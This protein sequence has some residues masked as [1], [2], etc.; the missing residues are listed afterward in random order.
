MKREKLL[1]RLFLSAILMPSNL[2]FKK[3]QAIIP[4]VAV[5]ERVGASRNIVSATKTESLAQISV[6][7]KGAKTVMAFIKSQ[8]MNPNRIISTYQIKTLTMRPYPL[9]NL[10]TTTPTPTPTIRH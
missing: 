9:D 10:P 5:A 6:T 1:K 4:R 2:R 7:A 3:L 8:M